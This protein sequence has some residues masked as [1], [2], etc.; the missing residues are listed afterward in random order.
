MLSGG[1]LV[2]GQAS[3]I[4]QAFYV[5]CLKADSESFIASGIASAWEVGSSSPLGGL[6]RL[7]NG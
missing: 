4:E 3:D 2:I 1:E 6:A 7:P 5:C